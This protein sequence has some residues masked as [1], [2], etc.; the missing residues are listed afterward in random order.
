MRI[1]LG[2]FLSFTNHLQYYIIVSERYY[3]AEASERVDIERHKYQIIV[4]RF[5]SL[6]YTP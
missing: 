2:Y 3:F 4:Q 5:D 6:R 1:V